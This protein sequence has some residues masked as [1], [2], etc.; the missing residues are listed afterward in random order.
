ML[1]SGA[2]VSSVRCLSNDCSGTATV[3]GVSTRRLPPESFSAEFPTTIGR[4]A[5]AAL[6]DLGITTLEQVA[7]M[8]ERELRAVHGVGP[9]A[10]RILHGELAK[11]NLTFRTEPSG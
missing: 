1:R 5:N 8:T 2:A 6:T 11:R 4:P 7:A 10:V 3:A 9:K